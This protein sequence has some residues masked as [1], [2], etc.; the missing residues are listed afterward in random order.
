MG[1]MTL[2]EYLTANG[3]SGNQ[4]ARQSGVDVST[5]NRLLAGQVPRVDTIDRI[6][7]ATGGQVSFQDWVKEKKP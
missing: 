6:D 4:F 3:L 2:Q 5:I 7:G 1:S